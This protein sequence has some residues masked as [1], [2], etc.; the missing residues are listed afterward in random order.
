MGNPGGNFKIEKHA[1][2]QMSKLK[3]NA[4]IFV[5]VYLSNVNGSVEKSSFSS[6]LKMQ[7]LI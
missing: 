7:T 6:F 1:T 3:E 4:D 2:I 5:V